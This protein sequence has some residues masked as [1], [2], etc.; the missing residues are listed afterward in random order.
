MTVDCHGT[1]VRCSM[2][3]EFD[4]I[5]GAKLMASCFVPTLNFVTNIYRKLIQLLTKENR[6]LQLNT[7]TIQINT[8]FSCLIMLQYLQITN[9]AKDE[10]SMPVYNKL[11]RDHI[12]QIIAA[13]GKESHTRILEEEE[14]ARELV[15]KLKEE[16]EE[17]FSAQNSQESLEELADMLEVIRALAVVHGASWVQLEALREKKAEARGG[18]QDRM[19]LID[20]SEGV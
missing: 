19:Y 10:P 18:F 17:Y 6:L 16:S 11:I 4:Y 8:R 12:P 14:Y 15:I 2:E 20:V 5:L 3:F 7:Q 9:H 1:D 13:N